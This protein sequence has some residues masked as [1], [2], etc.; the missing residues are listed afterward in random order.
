[1]MRMKGKRIS[2]C[3][4]G[5]RAL[6]ILYVLIVGSLAVVAQSAGK[7]RF[8]VDPGGSY[9]FIL[10]HQYRMQQREVELSAGPHHFTFWAP[11]RRMVDTTLFVVEDRTKDVFIRL[12]FSDEYR[13]YER[14]LREVKKQN[15][16][17]LAL[18]TLATV[19]TG[20]LAGITYSGYNKAH[21]ELLA[22]EE[23]YRSGSDPRAIQELK[24][25]TIPNHKSAFADKRTTFF[26]TAGVFAAVAAGSTYM[27]IRTLR[28]P[29][30]AFRDT[31]KVKFDGLVWLPSGS[32]GYFL[33]GLHI[34]LR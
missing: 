20:V 30:P 22:D 14:E 1:M 31:Q 17:G 18:P 5:H 29:A 13:A 16:L 12:P 24:E 8:V 3:P 26:I 7:L 33:T 28:K 19:G 25:V 9:S 10:D 4:V 11:E 23:L 32:S 15:L 34:D 21:N 27:I 6:A 2:M